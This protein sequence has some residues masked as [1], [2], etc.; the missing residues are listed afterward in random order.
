MRPIF[1]RIA[2]PPNTLSVIVFLATSN[3]S[4]ATFTI[5]NLVNDGFYGRAAALTT[6]LLLVAFG[7]LGLVRRL[8]GRK[9]SLFTS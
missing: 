2:A 4:V 5:M 8:F 7:V 9:I 1:P 3:N 6:V